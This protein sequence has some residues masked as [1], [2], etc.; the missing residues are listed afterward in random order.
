MTQ[1]FNVIEKEEHKEGQI[2][3]TEL[4][5]KTEYHNK[6]EHFLSVFYTI[7]YRPNATEFLKYSFCGFP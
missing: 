6:H 5:L 7:F 3:D 1:E 4:H 2:Y